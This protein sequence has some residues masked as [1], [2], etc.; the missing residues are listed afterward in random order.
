MNTKMKNWQ[1]IILLFYDI[2][3]KSTFLIN[4]YKKLNI[5]L[6][7]YLITGDTYI[8]DCNLRKWKQL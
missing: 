4:L 7:K 8:L 5:F 3:Y 1:A 6:K 2:S